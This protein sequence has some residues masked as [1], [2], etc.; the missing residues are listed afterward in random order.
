MRIDLLGDTLG[1]EQSHR[2][3]GV[4]MCAIAWW[5]YARISYFS[6]PQQQSNADLSPSVQTEAE[7]RVSE[8]A[9]VAH[10]KTWDIVSNLP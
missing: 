8:P 9:R 6:S 2:Q 1:T 4:R 3:L 10:V 7:Q 5:A